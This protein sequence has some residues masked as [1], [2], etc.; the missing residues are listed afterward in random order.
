MSYPVHALDQ[1]QNSPRCYLLEP[2]EA[3]HQFDQQAFHHSRFEQESLL[4]LRL[5]PVDFLIASLNFRQLGR[6]VVRHRGRFHP[7]TFSTPPT[8]PTPAPTSPSSTSRVRI[9]RC[10]GPVGLFGRF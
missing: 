9:N 4:F 8:L 1:V 5:C 2:A 6:F 3:I 7:S 10:I